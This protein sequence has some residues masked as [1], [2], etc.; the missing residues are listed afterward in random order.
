MVI[1]LYAAPEDKKSN[2]PDSHSLSGLL[3]EPLP[4]SVS[5]C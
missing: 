1:P 3:Y 5:G 2:N 4:G